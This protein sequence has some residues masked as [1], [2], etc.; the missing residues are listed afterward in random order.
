MTPEDLAAWQ[1]LTIPL[2]AQAGIEEVL[3]QGRIATG[4]A[5]RYVV[6]RLGTGPGGSVTVSV[7]GPPAR[8]LAPLSDYQ[9]KVLR[10]PPGHRLPLRAGRAAGR[11]GRR[12]HRA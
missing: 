11:P 10:P 4:G 2:A 12:V 1:R 9:Q 8:P 7:E 5:P 6:T 3:I